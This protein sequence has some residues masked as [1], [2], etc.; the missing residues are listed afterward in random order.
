MDTKHEFTLPPHEALRSVIERKGLTLRDLER[1]TGIR[2]SNLSALQC[3]TKSIGAKSALI[4]A[5]A[6]GVDY[7]LFWRP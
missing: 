6:L 3:G 2:E 1:R 7:T 5:H 4:L